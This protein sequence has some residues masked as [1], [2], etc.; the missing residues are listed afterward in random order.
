MNRKNY[1]K[2]QPEYQMRDLAPPVGGKSLLHDKFGMKKLN[3]DVS[4]RQPLKEQITNDPMIVK[5]NKALGAN[6][7]YYNGQS[8]VPQ[9]PMANVGMS[10]DNMWFEEGSVAIPANQRIIDNNDEID[11]EGLQGRDNLFDRQPVLEQVYDRNQEVEPEEQSIDWT[12][13]PGQYVILYDGDIVIKEINLD[14]IKAV[15]EE[16]LLKYNV[17]IDKISLIKCLP[18]SFGLKIEE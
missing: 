15:I 12:I 1:I 11:V 6:I 14:N 18:I 7:S 5:A 13:E 8:R 2:Q 16:M 3:K 4:R 9:Q 17:D 10:Q